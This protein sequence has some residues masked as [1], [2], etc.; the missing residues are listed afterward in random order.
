MVPTASWVRPKF[1]ERLLATGVER[2]LIV[3][4]A[5]GEAAARD[6]NRW[7]ADRLSRQRHPKFRP[8][9]AGGAD[10]ADSWRVVDF[11]PSDPE[12]VRRDAE[13]FAGTRR[14]EVGKR[15]WSVRRVTA[16][17]GLIAV[18]LAITLAPSH[19]R[20]TNPESPEPELVF[21]FK[22]FG[23]RE[24]A[25]SAPSA[26]EDANRPVHMRGGPTAKPTRADVVVRLTVN[27]VTE[28]RRYAAKGISNDGP[29]IDVWRRP[30]PAGTHD[31]AIEMARGTGA[32]P[33]RWR[34]LIEARPRRL[35]VVTYDPTDGFVVEE[36]GR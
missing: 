4:D 8:A 35:H 15:P 33:L 14:D 21:S 1:V 20:V 32:E 9:R 12:R 6:G 23:E 24:A 10:A 30:I 34:G 16:L 27:G 5:R 22:A 11:D 18:I 25:A 36:E 31:V 13:A 2:V 29:A 7:I 3:R 17:C 28:E 26:T 19:L